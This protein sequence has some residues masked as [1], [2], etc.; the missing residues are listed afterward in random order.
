M[1][2]K[3]ISELAQIALVLSSF[4]DLGIAELECEPYSELEPSLNRV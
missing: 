2:M 4:V 1:K 3:T